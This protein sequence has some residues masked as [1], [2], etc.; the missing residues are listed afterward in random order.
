MVES[1]GMRDRYATLL[2]QTDRSLN[3]RNVSIQSLHAFLQPYNIPDL[4][5]SDDEV[6][7]IL[8]KALDLCWFFSCAVLKDIIKNFGTSV[9]KERLVEYEEAF[10]LYGKRRFSEIPMDA[11]NN[12]DRKEGS[13]IYVKVDKNF[14]VPAG[15]VFNIE[16]E[17]SDILGKP[18]YLNGV[19]NECIK[20][21]YYILH[22][23]DEVFPLNEEQKERLRGIGVLRIYG[24]HNEYFTV[25]KGIVSV[26]SV[27]TLTVMPMS[28]FHRS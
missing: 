9:D 28:D 8:L 14:D 22:E 16:T 3:R 6:S 23:L 18:V 26:L 7:K 20:L 17:I 15:E 12:S 25:S 4:N 1:K 24:E 10:G 19:E 2:V 21:T 11:V 13:K 27:I 5:E